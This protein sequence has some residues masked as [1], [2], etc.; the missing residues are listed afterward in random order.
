MKHI[1]Y[2]M[3]VKAL[4][5]GA[6]RPHWDF[7]EEKCHV[8]CETWEGVYWFTLDIGSL[9]RCMENGG[10]Y[11]VMNIAAQS[12]YVDEICKQ[13]YEFYQCEKKGFFES[14]S[15][16]AEYLAKS[17]GIKQESKFA[18]YTKGHMSE[19]V[20]SAYG[21]GIVEEIVDGIVCCHST[22]K[23]DKKNVIRFFTDEFGVGTIDVIE[24]IDICGIET[25]EIEHESVCFKEEN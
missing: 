25:I 14:Y 18:Y 13:L 12:Y 23:N 1:S 15:D 11:E 20:T 5:A 21:A 9:L 10:S 3:V 24:E 6:F 2:E 22:K 7:A 8:E 4:N 19:H 16:I 17:F